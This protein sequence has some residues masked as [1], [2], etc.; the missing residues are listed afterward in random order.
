[1]RRRRLPSSRGRASEVAW[2]GNLSSRHSRS[3]ARSAELESE[4]QAAARVQQARLARKRECYEQA[5]NSSQLHFLFISRNIFICACESL[6][7][8][9]D[10][11]VGLGSRSARHTRAHR[12]LRLSQ[13]LP[14][15]EGSRHQE[16][17][18]AHP[19]KNRPLYICVPVCDFTEYQSHAVNPTKSGADNRSARAKFTGRKATTSA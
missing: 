13:R 1:M 18:P 17:G 12:H 19:Q 3:R 10:T 7:P 11:G 15:P 14:C 4:R 5:S 8:L 16:G 2:G 9:A 6:S